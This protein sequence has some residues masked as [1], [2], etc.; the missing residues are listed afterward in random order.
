MAALLFGKWDH[1]KEHLWPL[2]VGPLSARLRVHLSLGTNRNPA[3]GLLIKAARGPGPVSP[4][5]SSTS[6]FG[7]ITPAVQGLIPT[8]TWEPGTGGSTG[9]RVHHEAQM[10]PDSTL[11]A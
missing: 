5:V 3:V 7:I 8:E 2:C 9:P 1:I 6:V 4:A 11:W 10:Y